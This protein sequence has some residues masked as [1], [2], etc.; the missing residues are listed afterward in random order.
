MSKIEIGNNLIAFTVADATPSS[1]DWSV[2]DLKT[3]SG[4]I[5]QSSNTI[6]AGLAYNI[7]DGFLYGY[8]VVQHEIVRVDSDYNIT[9]L[10]LPTGM[11]P[12]INWAATVDANGFMYL[13]G[14]NS[15]S[16]YYTVDLRTSSATYMQLLDPTNAYIPSETGNPFIDYQHFYVAGWTVLSDGKLYGIWYGNDNNAGKMVSV[17]PTTGQVTVLET[18]YPMQ[19]SYEFRAIVRDINDDIYAIHATTGVVYKFQVVGNIATGTEL[20]ALDLGFMYIDA[21]LSPNANPFGKVSNIASID[22]EDCED[23]ITS[24]FSNKEE[25]ELI[26]VTVEKNANCSWIIKG[27]SISYCVTI[28]NTS[29]TVELPA[30]FRDQLIEGLTYING[31]FTVNGSS[32]TPT[33][34]GQELSYR[35]T[36]S[37]NSETVICFKVLYS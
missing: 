25:V 15:P 2:V 14:G 27:S 5:A 26:A 37:P 36:L 32:Q 18:N 11:L 1:M 17:A 22:I 20:G 13:A 8:D 7:L 33:V 4:E 29:T 6:L 23:N 10:G 16:V 3:L 12:N 28:K 34:T 24:I 30:T 35:V 19:N 21:V 9:Y 31:T